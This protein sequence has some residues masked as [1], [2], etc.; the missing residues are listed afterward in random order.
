MFGG[1]FEFSCRGYLLEVWNLMVSV[2]IR[3]LDSPDI[4]FAT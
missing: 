1:C 4:Q 2:F 3:I